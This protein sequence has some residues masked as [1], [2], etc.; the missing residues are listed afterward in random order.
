[1]LLAFVGPLYIR[2]PLRR[3]LVGFVL[4]PVVCVSCTSQDG[5]MGPAVDS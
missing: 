3:W 2:T 5:Q 4:G 1:M